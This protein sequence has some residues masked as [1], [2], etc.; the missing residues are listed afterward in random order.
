MVTHDEAEAR[1]TNRAYLTPDKTRQRM[2]TVSAL[3]L[4]AGEC[5][6]DA[7]CGTGLLAD[8][9]AALV[10]PDGRVAGVDISKGMLML[11]D[12]RRAD[13]LAFVKLVCHS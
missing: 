7:G 11:A 2:R 8:D 6:L 1:R 4:E 12:G 13:L 3:Q 9:M 5:V 10:G